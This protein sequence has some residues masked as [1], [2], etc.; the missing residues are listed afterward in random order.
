MKNLLN[1]IVCT[2]LLSGAF[3]QE[4]VEKLAVCEAVHEEAH[5]APVLN[6]TI[7][8]G[9][10][11]TATLTDYDTKT[12]KVKLTGTVYLADG[13]TPAKDVVLYIEQANEEGEYEIVTEDGKNHVNHSAMVKTDANGHYTFY[14][15]IPGHTKEKLAYR[16]TQRAQH[17]HILVKEPGKTEYE[18]PAFV[19]DSD[20]MVTKFY[21]KRLRKK[22]YDCVLELEEKDGEQIAQKDI[23]LKERIATQLASK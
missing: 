12:N 19:F 3:A 23:V 2:G 8:A 15:F 9:L 14:T 5:A 13:V 18:L 21:R 10:E 17:I 16:R 11:A 7:E 6:E 1:L 20:W 4:A 22:G